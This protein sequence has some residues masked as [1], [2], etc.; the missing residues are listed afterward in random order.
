MGLPRI[1]ILAL[2]LF[3][4]ICGTVFGADQKYVQARVKFDNVDQ[5]MQLR[6]LHL[7]IMHAAHS[8]YE[9]V[10]DPVEVVAAYVIAGLLVAIGLFILLGIWGFAQWFFR[11][12]DPP[13]SNFSSRDVDDY[14]EQNHRIDTLEKG[15]KAIQNELGITKDE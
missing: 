3:V 1:T 11:E 14:N 7:D 9:I 10:T 15:I 13:D 6:K 2:V 12:A 4:L 5:M 8:F